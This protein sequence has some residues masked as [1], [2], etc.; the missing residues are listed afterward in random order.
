MK[1][2]NKKGNLKPSAVLLLCLALSAI[3]ICYW[4]VVGEYKTN[5]NVTVGDNWTKTYDS[6]TEISGD[7]QW[8]L[9]GNETNKTG[10]AESVRNMG[11]GGTLG[12]LIGG[13]VVLSQIPA[14]VG[15][16]IKSMFMTV[17]M[18]ITTL[19]YLGIP[20][21]ATIMFMT[22]IVIVVVSGGL[23]MAWKWRDV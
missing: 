22:A 12:V 9:W 15:L 19:T 6:A 18:V 5:Y 10:F 3:G 1:K 2:A 16:V 23:A 7:L 21:W 8:D 17:G 13:F 4:T 14:M 11:T 20:P